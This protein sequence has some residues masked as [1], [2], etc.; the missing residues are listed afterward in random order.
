[1]TLSG[2]RILLIIGGG[3]AAYKCARPDPPAARARRR[4]ALRHDRGRAAVRHA[5]V[6][7]RADRRPCLHRPVRPPGR[8]G[9]RP[10]PAGA[11]G[12]PGRRRAGH[13]RPDGQAG[14][15]PRQRSRLDRA[16]GHRQAGADGA[17]DEPA[18][19]GASGDPPQPR[20][21]ARPTASAS[22]A[23]TAAR[24]PSAARPARPHGRAAGDRR[25]DRGAARR[26]RRSRSPAAGSSSPPARPTSR[27]TR[28]ATSPTARR[29]SRATPSP[30]RSRGS[31]PTCGW[32]PA[33][34][35][36]PIRPAST[37]VHV[38]TAREMRDA[39]EQLLP[40]DAAVFVAA[41]A[42]WRA[43]SEAGEKIKKVAGKAPP[44]LELVENPDIL[45]GIG[46]H[47]AAAV[48]GRRL[49]RRDP[50]PARERRRQAEEEGRR[51]DRRQRRVAETGVMGG[52]RNRVHRLEGRRRRMAGAE[53][54]R[55]RRAA[56][57]ADRRPA[58]DDRGLASSGRCSHRL[59]R[60]MPPPA[61]RTQSL[62]CLVLRR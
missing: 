19:V 35:R 53:Q 60:Q 54:G 10:H 40:A 2:K 32:S 50:E 46:H 49:C 58:E 28:C 26:R 23:R 39:V 11:R 3:I 51:L 14:Q 62:G 57:G 34:W 36:S 5:A 6:G 33:R 13:R 47:A 15:R 37:T 4:G 43:D 21:A 45:A 55:G 31:A 8:A 41:V 7:R 25:R 42:D 44:A 56:G 29:A 9:C 52:D 20:D 24:W 16:A 61:P 38:E 59:P 30:R 17:G 22:S 1:M 27:S 18:D 48:A 12:R